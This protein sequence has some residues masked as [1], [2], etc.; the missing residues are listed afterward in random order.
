MALKPIVMGSASLFALMLAGAAQ[1]QTPPATPQAAPEDD[2]ADIVV[3]GVRASIV[4]A[5]N[6]RRESTQ[7]VDSIVSEDVGKLPD[8]NVVEALQRVTGI[9]VTDRAGGE[10]ATITI[11]G[12]TDPLTTLNGR[13][14]FTAAGTSFALQDI[15]ANLVKQVDVY[16]TRSADQLETGLAGQI[17]VQTRRPLDFDGFTIS[18]L[19][20]GVYSELADKVNPNVA[21]LVSDRWETGI[22]DIGFLVNGSYT[23]A[24]FRNQ[25]LQAG[26]MVPFATETPPAGSGLTPLQRIFPGATNEN[27]TPGLD[28][29][30][31]TAPGSTLNINGVET[32]YYLAR[33]AVIASDLYGK[34]DRTAINAALQWAPNDSSV[35]TAEVFY[36][37]FKGETFN[38]LNFSFVDWW[39]NLPTDVANSFELFEGTNIIKSRRAGA[40]AGFNSGDRATSRTDSYVYAFNAKWDVGER[41]KISADIAYQD[42]K[43]ET[44]FFAIRT[45]RGPLD[46]DVDF[47]AGGGLPAYS[48][49][50]QDVLTDASK[51]TVGNLFDSG[52]KNTGSALTMM[53]DGE[54]GWNEGFLRRIKAGWRYDRRKASSFVRDQGAGGLGV[55]L[56]AFGEG[57]PFTNEGFFDGRANI[58]TSWVLADP[59][60]MDRDAV[61]NLYRAVAPGLL[62]SDQLSFGRVF[63][64]EESNLAAYIVADAEV[65]IFGRPLQLQ[66]GVRYVAIDTDYEYFDRGANFARTGVSTGSD[67]FLPSFTARYAITDNL[68]IR[69]NYGQTLRRPAFGDLNPNLALGGDL[70]R[71]GFGTGSSGNPNLR[72]TK[73]ENMDL[74]IE[75]YFD[76]NSAIYATAFRRKIEGLVVPLTVRE[77]IPNNYLPRNETYT[78]FFN[79][80]RPANASNGTLKGLEL[81][82]TYFPSYLPSVLDG[83]GFTG[84]ATIL[85]SEQTIPVVNNEGEITG[86]AKSAF[87]GVSK[88][89]YNATLAY[90]KG[91]IG[92]RLSY[93]WRKGFL[94]NN[95]ARAFANP[96]GMWRAPEKSLDFQLTLN[97]NEDIGITFDAVNI[98]KAKQQNY[99]KFGDVGNPQQFN[100]STLLI[101]RTFALGVRFKFD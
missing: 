93:I 65:E 42:S 36:T 63:G 101:D 16:K 44:S 35:Y 91:P 39:G 3:T 96:I 77:F 85:D 18:G 51:W 30:L 59:R 12:L 70:S 33:D 47:N 83:L 72:A 56:D 8:N 88:L 24:E 19:A 31:P 25:N 87:F 38:S 21:L 86:T 64:I 99:Y 66:G 10:A 46:I 60:S 61:R 98:T 29:G 40:V 73:S 75:W 81:G 2:V 94:N 28:A 82:L 100:S 57:T 9:Q 49:G 37:G 15:S 7:I 1:A 54:Y 20:R 41:G 23:R 4:G 27:W 22:G 97:L 95:E 67:D 6:V 79:I 26:A 14:I 13:N 89:S 92:A 74:A 53:L 90:D 43:N 45:D 5:L 78:E 48:F 62:L 55:T 34:R 58:P 80:T 76:R 69:F 50:N 84:S 71:I 32:P 68:R 11:R 52:T 17:D